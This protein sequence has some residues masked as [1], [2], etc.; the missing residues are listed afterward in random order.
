MKLFAGEYPDLHSDPI[1][2]AYYYMILKNTVKIYY[3]KDKKTVVYNTTHTGN[4]III[5]NN[6]I[7][8]RVYPYNRNALVIC[9]GRNNFIYNSEEYVDQSSTN[10]TWNSGTIDSIT[11]SDYIVPEDFDLYKT[12]INKN[13][14][15]L[16]QLDPYYT[17]YQFEEIG[18]NSIY[19]IQ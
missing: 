19:R 11:L 2:G 16:M 9:L 12:V 5:S 4:D 6:V 1:L 7:K 17:S 10:R 14:L 8:P 18:S 3:L 15:S 13:D